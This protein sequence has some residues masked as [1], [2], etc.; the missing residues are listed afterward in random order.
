MKIEYFLATSF[1]PQ[2]WRWRIVSKNGKTMAE[3]VDDYS[4]RGNVIRACKKMAAAMKPGTTI[5]EG[6]E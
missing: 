1:A 5:Q 3:S 4:K 2:V 6:A